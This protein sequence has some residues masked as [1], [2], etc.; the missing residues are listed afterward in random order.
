MAI[1]TEDML[2]KK[3]WLHHQLYLFSL[4]LLS[5]SLPLSK[6][7][8]SLS[9]II[10]VAN[11]L[12]LG[13]HSELLE[14]FVQRKSL[15]FLASIYL[16]HL[17]GML[18][19]SDHS[20][21]WHDLRIKLP[22]LLVPLVI[23]TSPVLSLKEWKNILW[24]F[25]GGVLVAT[26]I[27][28]WQLTGERV[29]QVTDIR[30]ISMF[31]SHIRFAL[32]INMAIFS[33]AYFLFSESQHSWI[34]KLL[35]ALTF[36]WLMG[37]LLILKSLTGWVVFLVVLFFLAIRWIWQSRRLLPRLFAAVF[38]V[39]FFLLLAS[40]VTRNIARFYPV[41]EPDYEK[42]D[43]HTALGNPYSHRTENRQ[44]E[45]GNYT[46]LYVSETELAEEWEKRSSFSY[47]G[48]D[49]KGQH[50]KFTLIRYLTSKGLRKDAQGVSLLNER[51]IRA[52]EDGLANVIF[53]DKTSWSTRLYELIWEVDLYLK[54]GN[55]S[56]H[57]VTQRLE[58]WYTAL[59]IIRRYPVFGVGTGDVQL[60]FDRQ[61]DEDRSVLSHEWRLR[62]HNQYL[63]FLVSFGILGF[64]WIVFAFARFLFLERSNIDYFALVFIL[65]AGLSMLNEDTLET[66]AGA[67]FFS[68][69]MALFILKGN[70]PSQNE[71][72]KEKADA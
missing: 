55:P 33:M 3:K 56:G 70:K 11:W 20:Y 39:T 14:K 19:S 48:L 58:Y 64:A 35:I 41:S 46:W 52:I 21:G 8:M 32:L 66:H 28:T 23:G 25:C 15:W 44:I 30:E 61:Y 42:L 34:L 2:S 60:A 4:V 12:L 69:F 26:L 62:A 67:T 49:R 22:L 71:R 31:H 50:L 29:Y 65:V 53:L 59:R 72:K 24:F 40:A 43:T 36:L 10:L 54:G 1:F 45:N 47:N 57:S 38:L 51:D 68:Y 7:G 5:L 17:L 9:I 16:I 18:Y 63:T 13:N 6:F 37:F 27:S